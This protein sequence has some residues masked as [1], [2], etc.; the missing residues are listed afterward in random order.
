MTSRMEKRG[1]Q[2]R[3]DRIEWTREMK[4][5]GE[6]EQDLQIEN[7]NENEHEDKSMICDIVPTWKCLIR[8]LLRKSVV[9]QSIHLSFLGLKISW[10][11]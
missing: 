11:M 7:E 4:W 1:K 3:D 2:D 8:F 10:K 5:K 6:N 9:F